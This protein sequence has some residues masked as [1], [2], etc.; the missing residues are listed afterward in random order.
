[1]R[2]KGITQTG[3]IKK[4][5]GTGFQAMADFPQIVYPF[6][7]IAVIEVIGLLLIFAALQPPFVKYSMPII[8]R[9]WGA[10]FLHYPLILLLL[11]H[12]HYYFQ[13]VVAVFCGAFASGMTISA[14]KQYKQ[15]KFITL[16]SAARDALHSYWHLL[17]INLIVFALVQCAF[18][19]KRQAVF[20]MI[21]AM[22]NHFGDEGN[23]MLI[24]A[25]AALFI[26]AVVQSLFV[27]AQPAVVIEGKN[28]IS[29]IFKSLIL[30]LKNLWVTFVLVIFPLSLF[31]PIALLKNKLLFL[32]QRFVPE[33]IFL[34]LAAGI[35]L[36][37]FLNAGITI[38]VS[39]GYFI[40]KDE[41][42]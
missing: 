29:A 31:L 41:R 21:L 17:A 12:L 30:T 15:E 9:F 42:A 18:V 24:H 19:F 33:V 1:M 8:E 14:F 22:R 39:A 28:F 37:F 5:L 26:G 38:M 3:V 27:F 20:K 32:M 23:W 34:V 11:S 36:S 35:L 7:I 2:E 13:T 25:T 4:A 6:A 16:R 40:I 10:K